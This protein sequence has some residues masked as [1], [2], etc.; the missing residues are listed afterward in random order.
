M[1]IQSQQSSHFFNKPSFLNLLICIIILTFAILSLSYFV[2]PPEQKVIAQKQPFPKPDEARQIKNFKPLKELLVQKG[3]PFE[4]ELVLSPQSKKVV[5]SKLAQMLEMYETRQLGK[6]I[7][8]VQL[9]DVLYLPEKVQLT[10][11][12]VIMANK[13]IFEGRNPVIKGNYKILFFPLVIDGALG[14][15]LEVAMKEQKTAF[16]KVSLTNSSRLKNFV[17]LLLQDNWSLTIDT[18]GQGRK[19]WLEKQKQAKETK[20]SKISFVQDN[21]E[22]PYCRDTSGTGGGT[23]TQATI[24]NS[25]L[26]GGPDPAI[27]GPPGFCGLQSADGYRGA[28]GEEGGTG[29]APTTLGGIGEP[30]GDAESQFN[31]PQNTTGTYIYRAKGGEGGQGGKGGQGGTGGTGA[32]GGKG[33]TGANCAC[34]RGGTG[35]GGPG[36]VGGKGGK[37]GP[38]GM[39][40]PGGP[41]GNGNDITVNLPANWAGNIT[42]SEDGGRGGP[43][44]EPGD[45]GFPGPSGSGGIGGDTPSIPY[46]CGEGFPSTGEV[47][48]GNTNLGYGAAGERGENKQSVRGAEG[49]FYPIPYTPPGSCAYRQDMFG[50]KKIDGEFQNLEEAPGGDDTA[51]Q[52]TYGEFAYWDPSQ[53]RCV[54][55]QP[56]GGSPIIIDIL[57]NGFNLTNATNGVS[58][59]LNSDG[60]REQLSWTSTNSDD[61]WLALDRNGNSAIDNG[62]ELFGNFTAQPVPPTGVERHG[63]LALA[64]FDKSESGGNDDDLITAEDAVFQNLRLWQDT[65]HNGI[66]ETNELKT[67]GELG[68]A[69]LELD[70][71]E[72]K[73]TDEHGNQFKYRA[74]V[75][76]AHGAQIGRWA[77]DVFLLNK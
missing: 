61:A 50:D 2:L 35:D 41:P 10:G 63:F 15:T 58:F 19:E 73:C 65:N 17:P 66:S 20:I 37:G 42:H 75:K 26:N 68:L 23:G 11:D 77:W 27:Q 53:C 36:G 69:E 1:K 44:G 22:P 7:K 72:S 33:G 6:K 38:G 13:V 74:K 40:G 29:N 45:A 55:G 12:T 34:F 52:R 49:N 64:V 24:G 70:Y 54:A 56:P 5:A 32:Q 47:G 3:V 9:A 21:C 28:T 71:K 57:G 43:G 39:G 8:G 25:G 51:C 4:P 62:R 59:D 14:T 60:V 30:G 18:S 48:P 46:I 31:S 76:D 67:L 16:S